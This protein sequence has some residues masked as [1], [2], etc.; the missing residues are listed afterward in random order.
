M[1]SHREWISQNQDVD[2]RHDGPVLLKEA[3]NRVFANLFIRTRNN[4]F[5]DLLRRL[6]EQS[7]TEPAAGAETPTTPGKSLQK[8]N[9]LGVHER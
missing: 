1:P 4:H 5:L 6:N 3:V 7:P 9:S 8:H 2:P